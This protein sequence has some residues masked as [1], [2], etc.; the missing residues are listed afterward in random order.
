MQIS[1]IDWNQNIEE[2]NIL[3]QNLATQ[4]EKCFSGNYRPSQLLN[5]D[6]INLNTFLSSLSKQELD[7]LLIVKGGPSLNYIEGKTFIDILFWNF[8][9]AGPDAKG[10]ILIALNYIFSR[11]EFIKD[12]LANKYQ[13]LEKY[14]VVDNPQL[15]NPSRAII[16][17][18][19]TINFSPTQQPKYVFKKGEQYDFYKSLLNIFNRTRLV[20]SI[21]DNYLSPEIFDYFRSISKIDNLEGLEIKILSSKNIEKLILP[22]KKFSEQYPKIKIHLKKSKAIHDRFLFVDKEVWHSGHSF[23]AGGSRGSTLIQLKNEAE[24]QAKTLF[25]NTWKKAEIVDYNEYEIQRFVKKSLGRSFRI[26]GKLVRL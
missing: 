25:E 10:V 26:S 1:Y 23:N 18:L 21:C 15:S 16:N 3:G 9:Q 6:L 8:D 22:A 7:I 5:S 13:I 20:I 12:V 17:K 11:C 19:N 4:F 14:A 2:Y 24:Y